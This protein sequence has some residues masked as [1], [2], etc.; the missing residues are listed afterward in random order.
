MPLPAMSAR[1]KQGQLLLTCVV[2]NPSG[3]GLEKQSLC[4]KVLKNFAEIKLYKPIGHLNC[5]LYFF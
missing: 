2:T 1:F 5:Q 4:Y 3:V